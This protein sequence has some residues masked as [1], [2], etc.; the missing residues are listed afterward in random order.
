MF[1]TPREAIGI[2]PLVAKSIWSQ[3]TMPKGL[4]EEDPYEIG[5]KSG[6]EAG[7]YDG[8]RDRRHE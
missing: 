2:I 6:Y 4:K 1:N 7:Y 3:I 8:Q 5:Y